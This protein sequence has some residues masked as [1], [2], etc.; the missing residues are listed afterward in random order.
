MA[1]DRRSRPRIRPAGLAPDAFGS[2][3]FLVSGVIAYRAAPGRWG[4]RSSTFSAASSSGSRPS[5]ASWCRSRA[6]SSTWRR[7]TGTRRS[8]RRASSRALS[9]DRSMRVM[10]AR[11]PKPIIDS[12]F[13]GGQDD[14]RDPRRALREPLPAR[15][16]PDNRLPQH[17][18][19]ADRRDAADRRGAGSR[20]HPE[21]QPGD[22]RDDLDG[23]RGAAADRREPAPQLHRPRRVSADRRDRAALHPDARR[24]LQRPGRDDRR[25]HARARRRRSC[26]ARCR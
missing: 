3:C 1:L 17:G 15:D 2:I 8:A 22:V 19:S 10:A 6:R 9:P 20:R 11:R 18:M 16:A 25:A 13:N 21:A 5:R 24:P 14:A 12:N 4:C 26:S 7:R 23:A